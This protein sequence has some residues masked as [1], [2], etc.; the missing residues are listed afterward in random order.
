MEEVVMGM[1]EE[2][3]CRHKE[4]VVMEREVVVICSN[5]EGIYGHMEEEV[6]EICSNTEVTLVVDMV[7]LGVDSRLRVGNSKAY[8]NQQ[9]E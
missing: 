9:Q 4:E 3:T 8:H 1:V 6:V 7:V 5:M 2:E